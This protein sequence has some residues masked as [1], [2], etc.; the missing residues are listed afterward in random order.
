MKF[1]RGRGVG[2]VEGPKRSSKLRGHARGN[3]QRGRR[4]PD[5][6]LAPSDYKILFTFLGASA[7]AQDQI[8]FCWAGQEF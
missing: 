8:K 2:D 7:S 6:W 4:T 5:Y 3:V 1:A